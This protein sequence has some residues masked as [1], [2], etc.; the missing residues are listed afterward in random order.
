MQE[1]NNLNM[2][3]DILYDKT[4]RPIQN[5]VIVYQKYSMASLNKDLMEM[6]GDAKKH[7]SA[8][9]MHSPHVINEYM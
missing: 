8:C 3:F 6:E 1:I 5:F 4:Y 2:T 7:T 9:R